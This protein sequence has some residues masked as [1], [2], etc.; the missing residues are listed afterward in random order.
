MTGPAPRGR[1]FRKYV[2]VLFVLVG[3]VLMAASLVELYFSYRE[4]QRAI[5]REER[6]KAVAAA[7]RIEQFLK[8]IEQQVREFLAWNFAGALSVILLV[9]TLLVFWLLNQGVARRLRD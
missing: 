3:G 5:V 6:A 7:G 2:V 8:E 1:L 9:V 4:T